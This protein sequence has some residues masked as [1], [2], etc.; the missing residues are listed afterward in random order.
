MLKPTLPAIRKP[1]AGPTQLSQSRRIDW[2]PVACASAA[3]ALLFFGARFWVPAEATSVVGLAS[4][5][6]SSSV[7]PSLPAVAVDLKTTNARQTVIDDQQATIVSLQ[8]RLAGSERE[9]STLRPQVE[10]LTRQVRD[11]NGIVQQQA[12]AITRARA[13]AVAAQDAAASARAAPAQAIA[14]APQEGPKDT[15]TAPASSSVRVS[16]AT[17]VSAASS[18]T[19]TSAPTCERASDMADGPMTLQ[20]D[21]YKDTLEFA[22]HE[23]L[24][25]VVAMALGCP[26]VMLEIKGH[27]DSRG[28]TKLK[29]DLSQRRAELTARFFEVHGIKPGQMEVVAMSDRAPADSNETDGGRARNRRVEVRVRFD[30]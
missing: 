6:P 13:E 30:K 5:L 3:A 18:G 7:V 25:Q 17:A 28:S 14:A 21:R 19:A 9:L 29:A 1:V 26:R 10:G 23:A 22:H 11:L 20:F 27:S 15:A 8:A 16:L 12:S 4:Q 2:R 24:N